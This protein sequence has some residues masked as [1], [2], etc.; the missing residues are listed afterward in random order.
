MGP[1]LSMLFGLLIGYVEAFGYLNRVELGANTAAIW[2]SK[3]FVKKV[4]S[5]KGKSYATIVTFLGFVATGGTFGGFIL[6]MSQP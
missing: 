3:S 1:K 6:P 4:Q 5:W 2:E